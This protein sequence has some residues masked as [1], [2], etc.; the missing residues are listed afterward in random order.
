MAIL[1][2]CDIC[3][4]QHRLKD[5]RIGTVMKC[6]DC[7]VPLQIE[8]ENEITE[9]RFY[10]DCGRLYQRVPATRPTDWV[11]IPG[12]AIAFVLLFLMFGSIWMIIRSF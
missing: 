12:C 5:A 9:E 11:R 6:R 4:C 2:E 8:R 10:E 3:G 1:V 7:G